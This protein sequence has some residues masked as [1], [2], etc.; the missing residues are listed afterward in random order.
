MDGCGNAY[1]M[2][3]VL[4]RL[5]CDLPTNAAGYY[6]YTDEAL[7]QMAA[8][9]TGLCGPLRQ[10]KINIPG[11]GQINTCAGRIVTENMPDLY[12]VNS[13]FRPWLLGGLFLVLGVALVATITQGYKWFK[14]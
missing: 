5:V 13:K 12:L 14:R 7:E 9:G 4:G 11:A 6:T 3:D 2:N 8:D 10:G 1:T